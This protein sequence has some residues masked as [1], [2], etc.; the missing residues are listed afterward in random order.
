MSATVYSWLGIESEK[1][2]T[3]F[4]VTSGDIVKYTVS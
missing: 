3:E 2:N 1:L 4:T